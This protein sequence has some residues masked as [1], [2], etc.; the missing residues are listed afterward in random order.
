[1]YTALVVGF[2]FVVV[3][4]EVIITSSQLITMFTVHLLLG[5]FTFYFFLFSFSRSRVCMYII[6]KSCQKG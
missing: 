1:M 3:D 4:D 5:I 6:C 2:V